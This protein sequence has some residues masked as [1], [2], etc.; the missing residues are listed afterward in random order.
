MQHVVGLPA[1]SLA[2]R[3]ATA[4]SEL[5]IQTALIGASA[6]AAHDYVRATIDIDLA[7]RVDP[8]TELRALEQR[9]RESG[10]SVEL[11]MPD[12]HDPIGGVL[13]VWTHETAD[14]ERL[15]LVEVVNFSN[16]YLPAETPAAEAIRNATPLEPGSALRC[17]TLRDLIA[18]KLYA[19]TLPPTAK[20]RRFTFR[21]RDD[22]RAA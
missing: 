3:I 5:G 4:A 1:L 6:L 17:A 21:P 2:E 7:T 18:L 20:G 11:R 9:L 8:R 13:S 10:M 15:D 19:R 22:E 16:P 12:Q 14:S